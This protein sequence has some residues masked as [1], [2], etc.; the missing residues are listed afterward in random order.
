MNHQDAASARW[1]LESV[2][3]F[4]LGEELFQA[5]RTFSYGPRKNAGGK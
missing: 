4:P 3:D 2:R 5:V 1:V